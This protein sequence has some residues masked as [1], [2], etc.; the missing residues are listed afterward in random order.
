MSMRKPSILHGSKNKI[1]L[2]TQ[3]MIIVVIYIPNSRPRD[4]MRQELTEVFPR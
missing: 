4:V 3:N 1:T 2:Y